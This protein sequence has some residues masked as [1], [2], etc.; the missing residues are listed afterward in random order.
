MDAVGEVVVGTRVTSAVMAPW[1]VTPANNEEVAEGENWEELFKLGLMSAHE[2]SL[3]PPEKRQKETEVEIV[4][5]SQ[6]LRKIVAIMGEKITDEEFRNNIPEIE[7]LLPKIFKQMIGPEQPGVHYHIDPYDHTMNVMKGLDT[8]ELND[9]DKFVARVSVLFHDIAKIKD[10]SDRDHP[11][12][13]ATMTEGYLKR[14]GLGE[15]LTR[16]ILEQIRWHDALGE[17][18]RADGLDIFRTN[19]I[20]AFFPDK[21][22]LIL[23]RTVALADIASI[24]GLV[25]YIPKIEETF[26]RLLGQ[27]L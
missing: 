23:H 14:M 2:V 27:Y 15:E 11:R 5:E 19:E 18:S 16:K 21:S 4:E 26:K 17:I 20:S 1:H 6:K 8:S 7:R 13:S 24:P 10:L 3:V 9:Q 12:L 25:K 22:G